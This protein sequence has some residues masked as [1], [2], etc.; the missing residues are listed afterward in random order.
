L[1]PAQNK[2]LRIKNCQDPLT[3]FVTGPR[4]VGFV[5]ARQQFKIDGG[6]FAPDAALNGRAKEL[7]RQTHPSSDYEQQQ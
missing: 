6:K 4:A 7:A 2:K 1:S 3:A 5:A